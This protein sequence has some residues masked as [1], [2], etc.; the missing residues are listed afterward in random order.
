[1]LALSIYL[2]LFLSAFGAATLLPLQSEALLVG[3]L[4]SKDYSVLLLLIAASVGNVL[5]SVINWWL[6]RYIERFRQHR[7]FPVSAD[8]L[9]RAQNFYASYG[10]WSLLLSWTPIIGDPLTL[11]A[12]I[13]R[14]PLWRFLLLVSI[15][16][17]AR[18]GI[19]A[20]IT[21]SLS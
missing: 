21:L 9:Q 10:R 13:M 2:S 15:A 5:G 18:Y 11:V 17:T 1:M 14:E 7:W 20:A 3:L 6:G 12:G 16:K 19:L 4:L 8:Q